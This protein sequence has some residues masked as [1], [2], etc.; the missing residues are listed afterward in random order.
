MRSERVGRVGRAP[1]EIISETRLGAKSLSVADPLRLT[2]LDL[3][4]RARSRYDLLDPI[5]GDESDAVAVAEDDVVGCDPV[6]ADARP[7]DGIR[8]LGVEPRRWH[9]I[10]AV[11]PERK[12]DL[13]ELV[14]VAVETPYNHAG[15]PGA[16]CL[17]HGKVADAGLVV[18]AAV[19]DDQDIAVLGGLECLEEDVDAAVVAGG[20]HPSGNLGAGNQSGDSRRRGTQRNPDADAGVEDQRRRELI[21][22]L[23]RPRI[24]R[25]RRESDAER[26]GAG[27]SVEKQRPILLDKE[28]G[29]AS[30]LAMRRLA[31]HERS[32]QPPPRAVRHG[33]NLQCGEIVPVSVEIGQEE[34]GACD[35][36]GGLEPRENQAGNRRR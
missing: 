21:E 36:R 8:C 27:A 2:S 20:Q 35:R 18:A 1:G 28:T 7:A 16:C 12:P 4:D 24:K 31:S 6:A 15:Q 17:K 5:G 30:L 13:T 11:A 23:G 22:P 26:L 25:K 34:Q 33:A 29:L 3:P 10:C 9:R 14:A 32:P 19:V